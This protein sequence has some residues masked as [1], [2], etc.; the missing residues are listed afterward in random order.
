MT[1]WIVT[2][3]LYA[4]DCSLCDD[5]GH[6]VNTTSEVVGV[7]DDEL[8]AENFRDD[9]LTESDLEILPFDEELDPFTR[10]IDGIVESAEVQ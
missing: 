4:G 9:M 7:F 6:P 1:V 3:V 10:Y 5:F 2:R 8:K